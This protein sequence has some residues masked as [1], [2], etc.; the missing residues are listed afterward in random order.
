M[1]LEKICTK[2]VTYRVKDG[3]HLFRDTPNNLVKNHLI[4]FFSPQERNMILSSCSFSPLDLSRY[5]EFI[6]YVFLLS[7]MLAVLFIAIPLSPN[8]ILVLG[9]EQPGGIL[10]FPL[11][12]AILD[13]INEIYGREHARWT[14]YAI[15]GIMLLTAT[16]IYI[17]LLFPSVNETSGQIYHSVFDHLPMLFLINFLCL[18]I[19]D[20]A[21]N[22]IYSKAKSLCN[23][24]YL[25]LRCLISTVIGQF[26]YS[27]I[28]I[29]LF[30]NSQLEIENLFHY[31]FSNY[32][33]KLI[34]SIIICIP[35]TFTS[36]YIIRRILFSNG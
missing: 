23:G 10:V 17:S 26:L 24:K 22:Y 14:V 1:I 32:S 31:I 21:N 13:I 12:F 30:S 34:Y 7:I 5:K 11:S 29:L 4:D 8:K 9:T 15:A 28:W 25:S 18:L 36:V 20:N 2:F 35:L 3:G 16:L 19:A 33:F 6:I 27:L